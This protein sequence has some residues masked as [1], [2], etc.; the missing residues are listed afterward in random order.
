[1][2]AKEALEMGLVNG[3]AAD[4]ETLVTETVARVQQFSPAA[5]SIAKKAFYAWD[6]IHFD[7]GLAK[8]EQIYLDELIKT[9]DANEGIRAYM[10]KRRP[11]WVGK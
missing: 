3:V 6:A 1:V 7:K 9:E 2:N 4:P 8:A 11:K 5:L 10:E